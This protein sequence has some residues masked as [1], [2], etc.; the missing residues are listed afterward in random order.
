MN[1]YAA[2]SAQEKKKVTLFRVPETYNSGIVTT[3]L[4]SNSGTTVSLILKLVHLDL[5]RLFHM[6]TDV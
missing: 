5:Y 3:S 6:C 1:R 2:Y 4:P